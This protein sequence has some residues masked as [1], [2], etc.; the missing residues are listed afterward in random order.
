[1]KIRHI[2][3][4]LLVA[5]LILTFIHPV[6]CLESEQDTIEK[7]SQNRQLMMRLSEQDLILPISSIEWGTP[8]RWSFTSRYIHNFGKD[9]CNKTLLNSLT[10]TLSPGISGGRFGIG[11]QGVLSPK[12]MGDLAILSEARV[13]LLRT[14]GNPLSSDPDL[15]F[16]GA[17]IRTSIHFLLNIGIGY[18]EQISDSNG[19]PKQFYG[20][21]I[22]IGI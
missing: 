19:D 13:V 15:T 21:H 6:W 5:F 17:E 18:Y 2:L 4:A 12:S 3:H 11:Y 14:W 8:D 1:M 16:V 20:F 22:G 10:M 9:R 7:K